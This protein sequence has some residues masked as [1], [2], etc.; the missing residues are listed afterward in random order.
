MIIEV[1]D[2]IMSKTWVHN[3]NVYNNYILKLNYYDH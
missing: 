1:N 3:N 2:A